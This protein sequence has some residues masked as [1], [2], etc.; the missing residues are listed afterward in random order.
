MFR[1]PRQGFVEGQQIPGAFRRD[2]L[3]GRQVL[4]IAVSAMFFTC[5]PPGVLDKDPPH[6]FGGGAKK[7]PA[8][9]P[10]L[11]FAVRRTDQSQIRLVHQSSRL[12]RLPRFLLRQSRGGQFAELVVD[13]RQQLLCGL[14]IARLDLTQNL[15]D[16]VHRRGC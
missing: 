16:V 4:P 8:A 5:P 1:K 9:V 10:E 2:D 12:Q 11:R 14:R 6:R 3:R 13:K 15:S 7:M